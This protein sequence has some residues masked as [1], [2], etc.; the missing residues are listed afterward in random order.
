MDQRLTHISKF[1]SRVLR[2]HPEAIGL[3]LDPQGW[4][5]V[6]QLLAQAQRHGVALTPELLQKVVEQNDKRRFAF[7]EDQRR[8]RASQGHS[9]LVDLGLSP[10]QPPDYLYHG[11]AARFITAIKARGLVPGRR[12]HMHLSADERTAVRVGERHGSPVVL[13]VQAGLMHAA[14]YRFYL[15]AN[16]VWLTE[17]VPAQ[18]LN[19]LSG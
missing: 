17:H 7:S 6:E 5:E 9:L 16:Q 1:L 15:S 8:I 11:T 2:H 3:T 19:F 18:F 10:M 14:G 4:A 12:N 13:K